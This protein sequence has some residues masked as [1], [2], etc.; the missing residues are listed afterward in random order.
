MTNSAKAR[1]FDLK[2][3]KNGTFLHRMECA[4]EPMAI[5]KALQRYI[6]SIFHYSDNYQVLLSMDYKGSLP[7]ITNVKEIEIKQGT[8]DPQ[9]LTNV[10]TTY[11]D[12]QSLAVRSR[13][14]GEIP[15][16]SPFFQAETIIVACQSGPDYF[17][18][19]NGRNIWLQRATFTEQ[20]LIQF[21]QKWIS[22]EAYHNLETCIFFLE[23]RI[24]NGDLIR[25]AIEFEEYDPN[26]RETS[27]TYCVID[28]PYHEAD[29]HK[30]ALEGFM[31]I[32]RIA[33]GKR[34]LLGINYNRFYILVHNN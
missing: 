17:H 6:N 11:P 20:D 3:Q 1:S 16:E 5:L 24:I 8:V 21:L 18:N 28:I 30:F 14:V 31:E 15:K 7:S 26:E 9:L 4:N 29:S 27:P 33:D 32:K 19:F 10:L 22:N 12:H 25:Q 2:E 13:I 23:A 34:A